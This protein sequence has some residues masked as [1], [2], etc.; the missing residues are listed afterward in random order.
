VIYVDKGYL[1]AELI[2]LVK[3]KS[4]MIRVPPRKIKNVAQFEQHSA[5]ET[6]HVANLRVVVEN[7]IGLATLHFPFVK[8]P[9]AIVETDLAA[10]ATRVCFFLCNYFPPITTGGTVSAKSTKKRGVRA[11]EVDVAAPP[12]PAN[13]SVTCTAEFADGSTT[14]SDSEGSL[15][16][17]DDDDDDNRA[18]FIL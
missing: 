3:P 10:C 8:A 14:S 4:I 9:H 13:V 15:S 6:T 16:S 17:S 18:V 2:A 7:F 12:P 11:V 1:L 5:E